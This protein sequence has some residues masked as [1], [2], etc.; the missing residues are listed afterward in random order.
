VAGL[1]S[2]VIIARC[3]VRVGVLVEGL[4]LLLADFPAFTVV[5]SVQA[6]LE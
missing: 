5:L 6:D 2:L 1:I 3:N 4:D